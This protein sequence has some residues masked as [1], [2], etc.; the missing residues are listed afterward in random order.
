LEL[1]K[2]NVVCGAEVIKGVGDLFGIV[3]EGGWRGIGDTVDGT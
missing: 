3:R 2:G 1:E